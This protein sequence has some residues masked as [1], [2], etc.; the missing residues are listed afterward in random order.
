MVHPPDRGAEAEEAESDQ[1]AGVGQNDPVWHQACEHALCAGAACER[2]QTR[3]DPGVVSAFGG[4]RGAVGW[5]F[6]AAVGAVLDP[7]GTLV[8]LFGAVGDRIQGDSL[9][10]GSVAAAVLKKS[11]VSVLLVSNGEAKRSE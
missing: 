3:P 10:F 8:E 9:N 7:D 11:R 5:E 6:G 2:K 4:R 1:R